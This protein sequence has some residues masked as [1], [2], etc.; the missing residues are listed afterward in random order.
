MEFKIGDI[1]RNYGSN[2]EYTI[3]SGMD[4]CGEYVGY[5]DDIEA[6]ESDLYKDVEEY[7]GQSDEGI[8]FHEIEFPENHEDY[9]YSIVIDSHWELLYTHLANTEIT[10][11][12]YPDHEITEDGKLRIKHVPRK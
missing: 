5:T 12:L 2:V 4:N 10:R 3:I 8:N 6:K 9:A 7:Y 1:V 11:K